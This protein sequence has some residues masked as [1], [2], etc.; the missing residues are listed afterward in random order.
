MFKIWT[1]TGLPHSPAKHNLY[2]FADWAHNTSTY[3]TTRVQTEKDL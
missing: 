1:S 3:V 2:P